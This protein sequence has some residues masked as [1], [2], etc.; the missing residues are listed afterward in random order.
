MDSSNNRTPRSFSFIKK[1]AK[2]SNTEWSS[3]TEFIYMLMPTQ[4]WGRDFRL[5]LIPL[6][7]RHS[8]KVHLKPL[9][10]PLFCSRYRWFN[11]HLSCLQ[12][13]GFRVTLTIVHIEDTKATTKIDGIVTKKTRALY[14]FAC[15]TIVT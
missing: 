15:N 14:T 13:V 2:L 12:F 9:P 7:Q 1:V 10:I 4:Q 8:A 3:T 11:Y 5:F 6:S